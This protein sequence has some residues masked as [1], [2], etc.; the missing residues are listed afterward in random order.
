MSGSMNQKALLPNVLAFKVQFS[1]QMYRLGLRRELNAL[2]VLLRDMYGDSFL[3]DT[4]I[5]LA[6]PVH[7]NNFILTYGQNFSP[8]SRK[9]GNRRSGRGGVGSVCVNRTNES[10]VHRETPW[11]ILTQERAAGCSPLRRP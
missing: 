3:A 9:S 7:R 11:S 5:V 6:H 8:E 2:I 10:T 1:T 4:R